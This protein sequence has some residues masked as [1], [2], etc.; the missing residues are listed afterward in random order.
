MAG[1]WTLIGLYLAKHS[2][3]HLTEDSTWEKSHWRDEQEEA[4]KDKDEEEE[5][6]TMKRGKYGRGRS[7]SRKK[8]T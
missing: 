1:E 6:E 8:L 7:K 2:S 5:A 4:G 3:I